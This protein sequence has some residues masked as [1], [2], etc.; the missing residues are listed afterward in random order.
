M[1]MFRIMI[2]Y[3][4]KV[5]SL[6]NSLLISISAL[7]DVIITDENDNPPTFKGVQTFQAEI[8][9]NRPKGTEILLKTPLVID[10]LDLVSRD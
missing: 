2:F 3:F 9:E 4:F 1:L 5:L 8:Q 10:D 6:S 7:L